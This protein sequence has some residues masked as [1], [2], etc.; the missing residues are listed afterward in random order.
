MKKTL[1]YICAVVLTV[2][3]GACNQSMEP[4]DIFETQ[5]SGVV[6]VLN[7]FYYQ[8]EMPSGQKLYFTGLD[9]NGELQ[10]F[11]ADE[12]EVKQHPAMLN[13]TGFFIDKEGTLV[14][15]RHVAATELDEKQMKANLQRIIRALIMQCTYAQQQLEIQYDQLEQQRQQILAYGVGSESQL[16]Q[17]VREQSRLKSLYQEVTA[18]ARKMRYNTS[19][20]DIHIHVVCQIGI[21]YDGVRVKSPSDFLK[22]NPC[23]IVKISDKKDVDLAL[24]RLKS[25]KTP[26]D[27]H[28]FQIAGAGDSRYFTGNAEEQKLKIDQQLYMIGYNAGLML[29][30]TEK[31]ISAQMTS[32]RVSQTPDGDRVLY[33]IPTVQGSSGSP[34][35]N[36]RGHVVAVNFAKLAGSDNF[37]FG[38][39]IEKIREFLRR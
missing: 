34:V 5:K 11:T 24:L 31:G 4:E 22:K 17:I 26:D 2:T 1:Q 28:V 21:S 13:G 7:K 19:I 38:I 20:D 15:N 23:E 6:L 3:M 37:N 29:A 14:T 25:G 32:G 10:G 30:N 35:L 33:S 36:D 16:L 9:S 18:T 12:E 39:P 8:V 27:A